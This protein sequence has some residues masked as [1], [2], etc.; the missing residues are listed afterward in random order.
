MI[1][2]S[3]VIF[4]FINSFSIYSQNDIRGVNWGCTMEEVIKSEYPLTPKIDKNEIR[5]EG[6]V[7][8]ETISSDLLYTFTNGKLSELRYIVYGGSLNH[9]FLGTCE[10]QVPMY[11][12]YLYTKF[13][14]DILNSK[15]YKCSYQWYFEGGDFNN[16]K[17]F[18]EYKNLKIEYL[19]CDLNENTLNKID[20]IGK[21]IKSTKAGF[22]MEN[23]RNLLN[24]KFN[25]PLNR[26]G[27]GDCNSRI[28]SKEFYN[29]FFWLIFE[30]SY[31]VK[32]N[33]LKSN[34]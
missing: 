23:K 27:G 18:D 32:Q 10:Y 33:M 31:E 28:F 19:N 26:E 9:K 7:L 1:I 11:H 25:N 20:Q 5:Y 8:G 30:P 21:E 12:K 29:I 15:N 6:V 22:I 34:F 16:T 3:C 13:I 2:K 4:L 24:V 17:Y 14:F